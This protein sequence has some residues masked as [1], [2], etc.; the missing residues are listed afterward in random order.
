MLFGMSSVFKLSFLFD[1]C[2]YHFKKGSSE[3]PHGQRI[4]E[5]IEAAVQVAEPCSND[6]QHLWNAIIKFKC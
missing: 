5:W 3:I 2:T 6:K 4:Q 1:K